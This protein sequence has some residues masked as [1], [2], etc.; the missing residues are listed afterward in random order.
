MNKPELN[1]TFKLSISSA[2]CEKKGHKG[3][4]IDLRTVLAVRTVKSGGQK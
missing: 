4:H 3:I 1:D 2:V